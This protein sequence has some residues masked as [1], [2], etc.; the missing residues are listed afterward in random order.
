MKLDATL[1]TAVIGGIFALVVALVS[2]WSA[3]KTKEV[4]ANTAFMRELRQELADLRGEVRYLEDKNAKCQEKVVNVLRGLS[5]IVVEIGLINQ[6]ISAVQSEVSNSRVDKAMVKE[7]L[8]LAQK[9]MS[10]ISD[11]M[12]GISDENNGE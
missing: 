6:F 3:K 1:I 5:A 7:Q 10:R 12:K 4:D 9:S 8:I 2:S 11:V